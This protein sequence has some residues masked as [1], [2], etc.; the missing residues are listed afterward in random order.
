MVR[1]LAIVNN[2]EDRLWK[3]VYRDGI[4]LLWTGDTWQDGYG[5]ISWHGVHWRAHRLA[6]TLKHG[7]IPRG[8][9]IRHR[10]D[11]PLC[12][13]P[14]CLCLGREADNARDMLDRN[15]Q[16]RGR[17]HSAI[18]RKVASRGAD[19]P[20]ATLT[21]N[22]VELVRRKRLAGATLK[23]LSKEY[24]MSISGIHHL[25]SGRSRK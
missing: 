20:R 7:P 14:R 21:D 5:K 11:K 13:S 3:N 19:H 15:R 23:E 9:L 10:C 2:Y 24:G 4:C 22:Q 16:S 1:R 18:M 6:Y 8:L 17:R 12:I 25:C